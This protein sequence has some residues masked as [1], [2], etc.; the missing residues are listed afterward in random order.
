[1]RKGYTLLLIEQKKPVIDTVKKVAERHGLHLIVAEDGQEGLDIAR[2]ESPDMIIVRRN[3]PVLD[4]LSMSVLLKQSKKT[5][6]IPVMVICSEATAAE[7]EKFQDAGCN[8]C[9]E[10]PFT[11]DELKRHIED[12][13]P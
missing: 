5:E 6:K 10:E 7:R 11:E 3:C 9:L 8:D 12:W 13:L 1:M 2:A 4:A